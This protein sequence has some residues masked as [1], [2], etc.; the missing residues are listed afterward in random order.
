MIENIKDSEFYEKTKKEKVIIDF[1]S[2]SCR[3]CLKQGR[4]LEKF[5]VENPDVTICKV[6]IDTEQEMAIEYGV[7]SIPTVMLFAEGMLVE[8]TAGIQEEEDLTK[9]IEGL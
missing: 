6:N 1:W 4:I 8:K 9:L 3:P 5:A 2:P 7:Q